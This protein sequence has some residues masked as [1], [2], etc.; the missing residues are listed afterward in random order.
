MKQKFYPI[1][2]VHYLLIAFNAN[3][4]VIT[5][6]AGDGTAAFGGDSGLATVAKLNLPTDIK[7]DGSGNV[8]I[9]DFAN[10]RVRKINT[11]GVIST[12]AGTGTAGFSGDNTNATAAELNNPQGL[13]IDLSGNIFIA[14]AG[15]Q[16][17]RKI[18]SLGI[19]TTVVGNGTSGYSGDNVLA[20]SAQ[21]NSPIS[22]AVDNAGNLFISD[23]SNNR[24]RKVNSS[25]TITTIAG[26]GTA[27][28]GGDGGAATAA[29]LNSPAFIALSS[30]GDLYVGDFDNNRVRKISFSSGVITTV[31]GNGTF[32]STGDGGAA[33]A[34]TL[35]NP[36]GV[37]IDGI[38]NVYISETGDGKIRKINA[39][40]IISPYSGNGISSYGGDNGPATAAELNTPQGLAIDGSNRLYI[41]D[42]YNNRI[43]K[44]TNISLDINPVPYE[45]TITLLPNPNNGEFRIVGKIGTTTEE[46]VTIEIYDLIGHKIYNE[47]LIKY[48]GNLNEQ[49]QL[50][51]IVSNGMYILTIQSLTENRSFH[52][53]IE[54]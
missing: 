49:I 20:T 10:N 22:V 52:L 46:D 50:S 32:G 9:A 1:I 12:V 18:N 48:S 47:R 4:Q 13:A 28:F 39:S 19:I 41:A 16:R 24:I 3:A 8:Y 23:E 5:T 11:A 17:I 6:I 29:M 27:S 38:G 21:L 53:M 43:R 25:G 15:N 44:V 14:D 36:S 2:L 31:A 7:I 37:A 26:N 34:A 30:T 42:E 33:T 35:S 54:N 40:G 51:G 45:N